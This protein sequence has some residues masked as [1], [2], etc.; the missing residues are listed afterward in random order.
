LKKDEILWLYNNRCK[1]SHRYIEHLPC[2]EQEKP[3]H[4]PISERIGHL[5]IES[6][7]LKATY[8]IVFSYA[9]KEDGGKVLGRCLRPE[10]I[11]KG[12]YDKNLLKECVEDMRKFD[13]LTGWY[14]EKFD[15]PFLRSRALFYRLDFPLYKE[16]KVCD[17]WKIA[18]Y[19]LCLHSNRLETVC[20]FY[21]IPAKT[22]PMQP[23]QWVDALSGKKDA[24]DFIWEHNKEDVVSLEQAYNLLI[25]YVGRQ[26]KSI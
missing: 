8:G 18:K 14:C 2:L 17:V 21:G 7:N 15:I 12:I 24:L 25:N 19:K 11:H 3:S 9:I 6:S 1:H 4:S 13:M 16:V 26:T 5:D 23:R 22:H 10:E 20:E